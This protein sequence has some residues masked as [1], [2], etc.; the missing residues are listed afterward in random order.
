VA[1]T[2][3]SSF[4]NSNL[5]LRELLTSEL[6]IEHEPPAM[7]KHSCDRRADVPAAQKTH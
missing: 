1:T 3:P 2:L 4:S 5:Q 6:S 7:G